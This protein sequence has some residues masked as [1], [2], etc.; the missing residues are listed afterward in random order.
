MIYT[1]MPDQFLPLFEVVGC[2]CEQGDQILFLYRNETKP[3]GSTWGL[4]AGKRKVEETTL[5]AMQRELKEETGITVQGKALSY[6]KTV[7]VRYP[8]Y[9][10]VFH[11]FSAQFGKR[12]KVTTNPDEHIASGWYSPDEALHLQLVPDLDACLKLVY[13]IA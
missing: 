11:M 12:P 2:F 8:T 13:N 3:E 1:T 9:D 10:F 6:R 7:Y 5:N 4:P